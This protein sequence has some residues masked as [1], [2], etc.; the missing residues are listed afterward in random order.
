MLYCQTQTLDEEYSALD[1][2]NGIRV[3]S[4]D[5]TMIGKLQTIIELNRRNLP[6]WERFLPDWV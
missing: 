2:P 4:H 6:G 3:I 5:S 1:I